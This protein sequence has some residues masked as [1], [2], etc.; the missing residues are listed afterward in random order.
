MQPEHY[1]VVDF[2]ATCCD[3]GAVPRDHMEI[4][5][6]GA[7]MVEATGL[8]VV[9][10]Y[11][12]F[13]RPVRHPHLTTFCTYLT[14]IQQA[15]VDAAPYF[16]DAIKAFKAWLYQFSDFVFCSWGDYDL[17]Q[18]RQDCAFHNASYPISA[19]HLN[20]KALIVEKQGL[21]KKPGLGDA[22][23]MAGL[24]FSGTHHRGIDD[25]RNIARILPYIF[26]NARLKSKFPIKG[27]NRKR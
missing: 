23:D 8:Q 13:I 9:S 18:L 19:P 12:S 26:G 27:E 10:E 14:S 17:K 6:I 1:L 22:V 2:E 16:A 20:L 24:A 11:Q 4:I 7:V 5:E 21:S 3:Q 15:D 25:A